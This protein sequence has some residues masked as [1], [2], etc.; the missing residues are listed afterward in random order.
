MLSRTKIALH[1]LVG[2]NSLDIPTEL[3]YTTILMVYLTFLNTPELL[4]HT[5]SYSDLH[6]NAQN[7]RVY[8][9][10]PGATDPLPT[11][12]R[13]L[14][15]DNQL[16]FVIGSEVDAEFYDAEVI[17]RGLLGAANELDLP[18]PE[19]VT[20]HALVAFSL[21]DRS[22][23]WGL[24]MGQREAYLQTLVGSAALALQIQENA[25]RNGLIIRPTSRVPTLVQS[26]QEQ[27]AKDGRSR[28]LLAKVQD[29]TTDFQSPMP[30][31]VESIDSRPF[32]V[33]GKAPANSLARMERS[34]GGY[35]EQSMRIKWPFKE[36]QVGDNVRIEC[37][38]AKRAQTAVHVYAARTGKCFSTQTTRGT[39]HLTVTRL[40][41]R[42]GR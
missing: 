13:P 3:R 4:M 23:Y 11:A 31:E 34:R 32:M 27:I 2:N 6:I 21:V 8:L 28:A 7:G 37:K 9:T 14:E 10:H 20:C 19:P 35:S 38:L 25:T 26:I 5:Y 12:L 33:I 24:A 40:I 22:F 1:S 41:D 36:M 17:I 16:L 18:L 30:H 15:F 39:G 29:S 42:Q